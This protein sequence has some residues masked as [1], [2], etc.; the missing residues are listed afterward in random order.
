[1]CHVRDGSGREGWELIHFRGRRPTGVVR[2]VTEEKKCAQKIRRVGEEEEDYDS[3][4]EEPKAD[5]TDKWKAIRQTDAIISREEGR[6]RLS[7]DS[8]YS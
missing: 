8:S 2:N 1:M 4:F 6:V 7:E 5:C 3:Q